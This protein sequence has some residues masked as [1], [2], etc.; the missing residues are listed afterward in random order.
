MVIGDVILLRHVWR[1]RTALMPHQAAALP[2][3]ERTLNEALFEMAKAQPFHSGFKVGC[4]IL[5]TATGQLGL[6]SNSEYG[7]GYRQATA[8]ALH[9][10]M[11][12][13]DKILRDSSAGDTVVIAVIGD[14]SG[15][16]TPCGDCRDYLS[17]FF[18]GN[19]DIL[20]ANVNGD[21]DILTLTQLLPNTFRM[22]FLNNLS[23]HEQLLLRAASYS[24]QKGLFLSRVC[25]K[26]QQ[27]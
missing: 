1:F 21:V 20:A 3:Y 10:E 8:R 16:V 26:A 11:S 22:A 2:L 13:A 4:A 18:P 5:N 14:A 17:T 15:P 27:Y 12:A 25:A 6:G 23:Y 19:T 9:A 24:F 7:A